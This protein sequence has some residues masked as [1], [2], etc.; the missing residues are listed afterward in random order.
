MYPPLRDIEIILDRDRNTGELE[1]RQQPMLQFF[2]VNKPRTNIESQIRVKLRPE[3]PIPGLHGKLAP[4]G[5]AHPSNISEESRMRLHSVMITLH[6]LIGIQTA[7]QLLKEGPQPAF[8]IAGTP[9][10]VAHGRAAARQ[11]VQLTPEITL[12]VGCR[13]QIIV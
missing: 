1:V 3:Q 12:T 7:V 2:K 10:L 6:R 5:I 4:A 8:R 9:D 11:E 13:L